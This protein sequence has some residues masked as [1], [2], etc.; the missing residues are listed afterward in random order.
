[1]QPHKALTGSTL[2]VSEHHYQED[3][4]ASRPTREGNAWRMRRALKRD[5]ASLD[6]PSWW[7]LVGGLAMFASER[8]Q[9]HVERTE[10]WSASAFGPIP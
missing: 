1:V 5:I 10:H 4:N 7:R 8:T 2:R 3:P 9:S 6:N